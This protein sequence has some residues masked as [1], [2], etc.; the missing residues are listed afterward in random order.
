MP[1]NAK[2][3][4]LGN[5]TKDP[6]IRDYNNSKILAFSVGV[7]T[8]MKDDNGN[9][10]GN[11]YDV[12][13]WGKTGEFVFPKLQKGTQVLVTGDLIQ[14]TFTDKNGATRTAMKI[15]A[16]DV[17]PLS[18]LKDDNNSGGSTPAKKQNNNGLDWM[19]E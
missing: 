17:R 7:Q 5:L 2:I 19:N 13:V 11:F 15:T 12:G 9:Y 6:V 4:I 1:N 14:T 10:I 8:T 18:K 16:N 3:T